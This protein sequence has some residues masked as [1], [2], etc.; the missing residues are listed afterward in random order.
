[1]AQSER[2]NDVSLFSGYNYY[3]FYRLGNT[4]CD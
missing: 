3:H 2:R 1:M 4:Y